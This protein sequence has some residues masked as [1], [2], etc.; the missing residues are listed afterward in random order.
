MWKPI[1]NH[2][3]LSRLTWHYEYMEYMDG[4]EQDRLRHRHEGLGGTDAHTVLVS[5]KGAETL[6][7]K[8]IAAQG[9]AGN[10][11]A[12]VFVGRPASPRSPLYWGLVLEGAIL[13]AVELDVRSEGG[14]SSDEYAVLPQPG[15]L[16]R[17]SRPR[18]WA[19]PDGLGVVRSGDKYLP[20]EVIEAKTS[21]RPED[22]EKHVPAK[23][24]SQVAWYRHILGIGADRLGCLLNGSEFT[25]YANVADPPRVS[26]VGLAGESFINRWEKDT[27]GLV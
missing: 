16:R 15:G 1:S 5:G 20:T 23:Y 19:T 2:P 13:D 17:A 26:A 14:L 10:P 4:T 6:L 25:V 7:R 12:E 3:V 11:L 8:K 18:E 22:W 9:D 27:D 21:R 24:V